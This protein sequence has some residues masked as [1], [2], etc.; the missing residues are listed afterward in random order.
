MAPKKKP[1]SKRRSRVIGVR[2]TDTEKA[3]FQRMADEAGQDLSRWVI[4]RLREAA[5]MAVG[6]DA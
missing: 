1:K 2:A 5:G 3:T 4:D 6:Q